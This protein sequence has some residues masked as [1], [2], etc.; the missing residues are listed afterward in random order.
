M[1]TAEI[2]RACS[3][4]ALL[5]LYGERAAQMN[6]IHLGATWSRLVKVGASGSGRAAREQEWSATEGVATSG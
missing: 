4:G 5:A 6:H 3:T 1:L 2:G